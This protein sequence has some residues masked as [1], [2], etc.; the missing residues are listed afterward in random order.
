MTLAPVL[1]R[2]F[3]DA[4]LFPPASLPMAAALVA[5]E[6]LRTDPATAP[7]IGPFLCGAS[8]F[9]ELEACLASGLARPPEVGIIA[10]GGDAPW[11]TIYGTPGVVQVE[12]PQSARPPEPPRHVRRYVEMAR[13]TEVPDPAALAAAL[14][15]IAASG[16]RAKLR[17]GGPRA[18]DVPSCEWLAVAL[19]GCAERGLALKATAGLHQPFRAGR[20]E[21]V[22]HHG[23]VN[24]L[25][26][27]GAARSGADAATVAEI[28]AVTED[29][30]TAALVERAAGARELLMSVGTCS[31]DETVEGLRAR[32]LL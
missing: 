22:P 21:A 12:A 1:G 31:V 23:L 27:A 29:G 4:S 18:E 11:A 28:L 19:V 20:S 13:P 32:G 26:A 3:D 6:R 9:D 16:V 25:A 24:L 8:R 14:D 10:Y 2:L 5:H 30:D 17:C 7:L 15:E